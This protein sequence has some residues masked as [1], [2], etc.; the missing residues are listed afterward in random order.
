M[1]KTENN[2]YI[3]T[4]AKGNKQESIDWVQSVMGD[5]FQ[6][7]CWFNVLKY[8]IRIYDKHET[9]NADIK[10]VMHY[11]LFWLNDLNGNSASAYQEDLFEL[12]KKIE[13]EECGTSLDFMFSD[14]LASFNT[15]LNER[16]KSSD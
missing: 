10:K 13:G 9:P 6:Y 12:F 8:P 7:G 3:K 5:R 2:H 4:D 16:I 15:L 11:C 1:K 14:A